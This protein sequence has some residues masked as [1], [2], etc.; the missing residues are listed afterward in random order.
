MQDVYINNFCWRLSLGSFIHRKPCP[1]KEPDLVLR[2]WH[3]FEIKSILSVED[4][5]IFLLTPQQRAH[6]L[7]R[8]H[9]E[10][11]HNV[12]K[13]ISTLIQDYVSQQCL[14]ISLKKVKGIISMDMC[15]D[16]NHTIEGEHV[17]F[18]QSSLWNTIWTSTTWVC[19]NRLMWKKQE[20]KLEKCI[21]IF[22]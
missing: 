5:H 19:V 21:L 12:L 1:K 7:E 18:Q 20:K 22:E 14:A 3:V 6:L 17:I 4:K 11:V 15:W 9:N 10:T 16:Q 2:L 8:S 13:D